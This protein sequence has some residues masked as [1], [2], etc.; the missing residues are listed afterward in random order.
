MDAPTRV[1]EDA[2]VPEIVG[3]SA[4]ALPAGEDAAAVTLIDKAVQDAADEGL[5]D[6]DLDVKEDI[7]DFADEEL[8]SDTIRRLRWWYA[9]RKPLSVDIVG[10]FGGHELFVIHGESLIRDCISRGKVDVKGE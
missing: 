6:L 8:D 2:A 1:P 5:E 3:D 7:V 4:A 9:S 10:D